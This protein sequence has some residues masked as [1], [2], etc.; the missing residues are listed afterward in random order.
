M[1]LKHLRRLPT[2]FAWLFSAC[3]CKPALKACLQAAS[4]N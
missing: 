3:S 1:R 4:L 2:L